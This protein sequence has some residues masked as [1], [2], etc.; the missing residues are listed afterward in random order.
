MAK[1]TKESGIKP[2]PPEEAPYEIPANWQWVRLGD[3]LVTIQYGTSS[4]SHK[5]GSVPVLRMGNI[6]NGAIDW[7]DLKY[8]SDANDIKK[9]K[10]EW[11][12]ILFN[13]TNSPELVGKTAIYRSDR[14][15]LFAGYLIRL[16]C[17]SLVISLFINYFLNS[18]YAKYKCYLTKTDGVSQ[19]NINSKKLS[20]FEVPLPPLPEQERIVRRVESLL[21][22]LRQA[23]GLIEEARESFKLRREAIL[24]RA[25]RGELTANWRAGRDCSGAEELL[26]KV[27]E[28]G[29]AAKER[30]EKKVK[31]PTLEELRVPVGEQP[32]V[33]PAGWEWV[34]LGDLITKAQYGTSSKSEKNGSVPVLRMGN[35][36]NGKIDWSNLKY[37]TDDN[38]IMKYKLEYNDI[39]FNRTNSPELVGKTAIY[40]SDRE[41]IFAGYLIRIKCS[42]LLVPLFASYFL[43]SPYSKYKCYMTK[44]DGVSQSNINAQKLTSFEIPLPPLAEQEEIVRRLER[45]LGEEEEALG[46]LEMENELALLE[47]SILA[48]AFRGELGTNEPG[49]EPV[50]LSSI[51]VTL[52]SSP[53]DRKKTRVRRGEKTKKTLVELLQKFGP[54]EAGEALRLSGL[55]PAD[56]YLELKRAVTNKQIKATTGEES[57]AGRLELND[58][59]L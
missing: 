22:Q 14:E 1:R 11:D 44:T 21:E 12:D 35:I 20:T 4:K 2:I 52:E 31:V 17:S 37:T 5:M 41:A 19:S 59:T 51:V 40:R 34:R 6:Q 57:K 56:F 46:L 8:T 9:Y 43:N 3:V 47:K 10:L 32:Y 26:L 55:K 58:E 16:K 7:T 53:S 13:R 45:L 24:A 29:R 42:T 39:L 25:F 54:L 38:D 36:Q 48:R 28:E 30:G 50:D 18:P 15:A 23:K 27:I 33:L 49:E